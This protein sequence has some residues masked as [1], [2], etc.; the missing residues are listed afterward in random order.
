MEGVCDE[1]FEYIHLFFFNEDKRCE[2]D[3]RLKRIT[4]LKKTKE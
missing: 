1:L 2:D 3:C 4:L